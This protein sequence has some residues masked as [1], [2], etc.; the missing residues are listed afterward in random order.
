VSNVILP[1]VV[2]RL[3]EEHPGRDIRLFEEETDQLQ[4]SDLELLFFDGRAGGDLQH[5]KL[6]DHPALRIRLGT[7]FPWCPDYRRGQVVGAS[8]HQ[9]YVRDLWALGAVLAGPGTGGA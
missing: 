9:H 2:R 6:L 1:T 8:Q 3:R 5:L 7:A 4:V